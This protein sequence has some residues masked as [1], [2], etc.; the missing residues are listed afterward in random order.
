MV[1]QPRD[2]ADLA[3]S[4]ET[5]FASELYRE[6]ETRRPQIREFANEK[7]S[8]AQVGE[9]TARVYAGLNQTL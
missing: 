2:S 7:Y 1:C 3:K 5:Y 4:I 9:M 8:W 6:L